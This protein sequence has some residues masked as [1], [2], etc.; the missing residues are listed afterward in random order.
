M[1]MIFVSTYFCHPCFQR[2]R[3][4]CHFPGSCSNTG[5]PQEFWIKKLNQWKL[6]ISFLLTCQKHSWLSRN[7][8][9]TWW[10]L[11]CSTAFYHYRTGQRTCRR[12]EPVPWTTGGRSRPWGAPHPRWTA[13]NSLPK[14]SISFL[15]V[16]FVIVITLGR[17]LS[18]LYHSFGFWLLRGHHL[19]LFIRCRRISGRTHQHWLPRHSCLSLRLVSRIQTFLKIK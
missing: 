10:W 5:V 14:R 11:G 17:Q 12:S 9:H 3:L 8:G 1:K 16:A 15:F 19:L 2:T 13:V 7:R 4:P 18:S 6:G